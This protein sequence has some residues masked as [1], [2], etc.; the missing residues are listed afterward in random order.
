MMFFMARY[1]FQNCATKF[2]CRRRKPGLW[3]SLG[4]PKRDEITKNKRTLQLSRACRN[5]W[6][7]QNTTHKYNLT[8]VSNRI[9]GSLVYLLYLSLGTFQRILR[10]SFNLVIQ[11]AV[12]ILGKET[13]GDRS[14]RPPANLYEETVDKYQYK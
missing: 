12:P 2:D 4:T 13:Y 5:F 14:V 11:M 7:R 3:T 6:G 10:A 8:F 1:M 9:Q